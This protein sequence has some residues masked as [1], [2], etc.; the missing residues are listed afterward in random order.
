MLGGIILTRCRGC[1]IYHFYLWALLLSAQNV[2]GVLPKGATSLLEDSKD[3]A[4]GSVR[5]VLLG[6]VA[7]ES[8][9][10]RCIHLPFC[11]N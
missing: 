11:L 2:K 9:F 3:D 5:M 8:F 10:P 7:N 1:G 6:S 4:I